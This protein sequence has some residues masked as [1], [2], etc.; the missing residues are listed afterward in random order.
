MFKGF[1]C[2]SI[3]VPSCDRHNSAK[4]GNDQAIVNGLLIP[5][6]N[7]SNHYPLEDEIPFNPPSHPSSTPKEKL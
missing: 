7:G 6:F 4:G 2:D 5:L 3:T 1:E